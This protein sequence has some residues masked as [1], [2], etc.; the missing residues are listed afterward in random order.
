MPE[1]DSLSLSSEG[2]LT[3][4]IVCF[5]LASQSHRKRTDKWYYT[6]TVSYTTDV[7]RSTDWGNE[8]YLAIKI[9]RRVVC[10]D[11][12][13][14]RV[15]WT[16]VR[17][18]FFHFDR[19]IFR[20]VRKIAKRDYSFDSSVRPSACVFVR[21]HGISW[22]ALDRFREIWYFSMFLKSVEKIQVS[23]KS[24]K[25]KKYLTWRP[26]YISDNISPNSC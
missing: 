12:T 26:M 24:D 7:V 15:C 14:Y 20:R 5:D 10:C 2:E 19:V 22:L 13:D 23:L 11:C 6:L 3:V 17:V 4:L 21:P 9:N 1:M 8:L 25:Q 16:Y 18:Y